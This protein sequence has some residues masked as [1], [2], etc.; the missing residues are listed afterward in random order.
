MRR[1]HVVRFFQHV[2]PVRAAWATAK[3]RSRAC[4]Q[5]ASAMPQVVAKSACPARTHLQVPPSGHLRD[6]PRGVLMGAPRSI[7]R[8]CSEQRRRYAIRRCRRARRRLPGR[9]RTRWTW[10]RID[11]RRGKSGP[12]RVSI[13]AEPRREVSHWNDDASTEA[14]ALEVAAADELIGGRATDAEDLGRLLDGDGEGLVRSHAHVG[15][16]RRLDFALTSPPGPARSVVPSCKREVAREV[17]RFAGGEPVNVCAPDLSVRPFA[18]RGR[19][20][21]AEVRRSPVSRLPR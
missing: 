13:D 18:Q 4:S 15:P 11:G 12:D 3:V 7:G 16:R 1:R 20:L 21:S 14:D 17:G 19:R 10:W 6:L 8:L 9:C 5:S 2:C